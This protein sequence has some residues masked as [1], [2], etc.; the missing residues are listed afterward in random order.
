MK[1][2]SILF[3]DATLVCVLC[4]VFGSKQ[5]KE[6]TQTSTHMHISIYTMLWHFHSRVERVGVSKILTKDLSH[7]HYVF[8]TLSF[9]LSLALSLRRRIGDDIAPSAVKKMLCCFSFLRC[10]CCQFRTFVRFH[11]S[12]IQVLIEAKLISKTQRM[13]NC[14]VIILFLHVYVY[15][16]FSHVRVSPT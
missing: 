13:T 5:N 8:P 2:N 6:Q 3:P 11:F 1:R 16:S 15:T 10:Q 14:S 12:Q 7:P 4:F 9:V